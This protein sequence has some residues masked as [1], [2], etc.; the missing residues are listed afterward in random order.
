MVSDFI[1]E[2][3]GHLSLTDEEFAASRQKYP[4][5]KPGLSLPGRLLSMEKI[6]MVIGHQSA[7][8]NSLK[9]R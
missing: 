4:Q 7:S 8:W 2:E 1:S 6:V 3:S 9:T 5:L